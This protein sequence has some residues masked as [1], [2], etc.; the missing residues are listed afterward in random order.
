MNHNP[1]HTQLRVTLT[2]ELE[3]LLR[4]RA[5][6]FGLTMSAYVRNLIIQDLRN[7][8]KIDANRQQIDEADTI[9][10]SFGMNRRRYYRKKLHELN[11]H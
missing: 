5:K 10:D 1:K 8:E 3:E 11:G 4:K 6:R 7:I 9:D 2:D